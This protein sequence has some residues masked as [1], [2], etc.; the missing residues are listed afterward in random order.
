MSTT[1][2]PVGT[3]SWYRNARLSLGL[4]TLAG[5]GLLVVGNVDPVDEMLSH[6]IRTMPGALLLAVASCGLSATGMWL[7]TGARRALRNR[8]L[9]ILLTV[10]CVALVAVAF[11]PTNLPGTPP[12]AA[13]A[14]HRIGAGLMAALPPLIALLVAELAGRRAESGRTRLLRAAGL[15]TLAACVAFGAVHGPAVLLGADIPPYAGLSERIL[16]VLILLVV[17]LC[18]W[19]I[20]GEEKARWT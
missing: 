1:P 16:L 6:S 18:A 19:V 17:G 4:S 9:S 7:L 2:A 13:A 10:W 8:T 20:Q 14:V 5:G 11:F 12:D 3:A 15:S